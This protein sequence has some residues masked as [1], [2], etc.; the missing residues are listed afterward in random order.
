MEDTALQFAACS[1]ADA[2]ERKKK[3]RQQQRLTT[4]I[5]KTK[6]IWSIRAPNKAT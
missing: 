1:Q 6:Y 3:K 4:S 2:L 5:K